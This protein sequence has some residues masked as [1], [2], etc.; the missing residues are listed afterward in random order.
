MALLAAT[1]AAG[2]VVA[3]PR[4]Q[5][6]PQRVRHPAGDARAKDVVRRRPLAPQRGNTDSLGPAVRAPPLRPAVPC[7]ATQESVRLVLIQILNMPAGAYLEVVAT[8]L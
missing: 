5:L 7:D 1:V 8:K 2:V 6:G 3:C 4:G